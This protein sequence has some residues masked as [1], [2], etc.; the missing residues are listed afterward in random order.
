M[1][2][3]LLLYVRFTAIPASITQT[4][5]ENKQQKGGAFFRIEKGATLFSFFV[6]KKILRKCLK[7]Q[8]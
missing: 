4:I 6:S 1:K 2:K 3:T 7:F 8:K 5:A